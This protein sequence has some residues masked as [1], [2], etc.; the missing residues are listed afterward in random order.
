MFKKTSLLL[1][2]A[3][4][5]LHANAYVNVHSLDSS[6][7]IDEVSI[8]ATA[9]RNVDSIIKTHPLF[10]NSGHVLREQ[11]HIFY[12]DTFDFYIVLALILAFGV[13][14]FAN[15]R[16][17]QY[18][19]RAFRS[20]TFSIQQLKDQ[21]DTAVV[22]NLLMNV[23]FAASAGVY[24]YFA[25]KLYLPQRYVAYSPSLLVTVLIAGLG[26]LY[27]AKYLLMIFSGHVFNARSVAGHYMYNVLLINKI[28]AIVLLP[29]IVILA[30]AGTSIAVPAMILS[31][32]LI[33][34]LL[35]NRYI[36]SWQV[37]GSFFQYGKFHFFAYL[38]ASEILPMAVLVK[39]LIREMYY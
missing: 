10:A 36:R 19:L 30:F 1:V 32:F 2:I 22:P 31:L 39:L 29:F 34:G 15:P 16:Y 4:L 7:V 13:M 25:F 11:Q 23:L 21:L 37:L 9:V 12:D 6:I 33:G 3:L 24:C 28:I 14:R 27:A 20:P 5:S 35:I 17:F 38:C 26:L 8:A 18:L